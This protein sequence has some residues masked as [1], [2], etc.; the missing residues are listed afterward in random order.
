MKISKNEFMFISKDYTRDDRSEFPTATPKH[1]ITSVN[2]V[3]TITDNV[4]F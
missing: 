3:L 1:N 4:S 2:D